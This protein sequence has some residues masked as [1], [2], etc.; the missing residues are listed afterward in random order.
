MSNFLNKIPV[1][2]ITSFGNPSVPNGSTFGTNFSILQTGG[3]MEVFTLSGLTYTIPPATTGIIEF[4]G[5]SIPIQFTKGSGSVFSPDVLTL[6]SDN[7]SSGRRKLGMLAY[8]YE[9]NKIYQF[10]I[11][12]YDTLWNSATGATG[13][14]GPTVV[15]SDFG[16]TVKNNSVAGQSF[17]NAWT[18]ST[19]S[20]VGGYDDTNASWRVLSTG[21]SGGGGASITGGTFDKNTETLSLNNSTGGTITITGFTDVFVTGGTYSDGTTT[22]TNN[23]GGTFTVSGYFTGQTDNY[24]TGGTFNKNTETLSLFDLTGGT[25][26]ITG[27]TDVFVTG[28]TYSGG[29]II[30]TNNSGGTFNVE[31]LFTGATDVFVTGGTYSSGTTTFTNNTGGTFQ[32]TG[33]T[34]QGDYVESVT[35]DGV[36]NTDPLNPVISQN[37][38]VNVITV[39]LGDLGLLQFE[40]NSTMLLLANS[41]LNSLNDNIPYDT[42]YQLEIVEGTGVTP[43]FLTT[44]VSRWSV[45]NPGD[46]I[47]LP[48]EVG[49]SYSGGIDWGD[50]TIT[51]N[52]YSNRTHTYTN[53]GN[54]TIK[55]NGIISK[56]NFFTGSNVNRANIREIIQWGNLDIGNN[57][58][59][60]LLCSNLVLTGVTD[61]LKL[62]SGT[63]N[64]SNMFQLCTS[65]TSINNMNDW[66]TSN[67]TNMSG[68]FNNATQFNQP[69]G[70]WDVSNV[71]IMSSMF[72]NCI[73][74][75]QNIGSWDVSNVTTMG[76]MFFITS[77]TGNF[78]NGGSPSI[79]NWNTVSVT[80]MSYMFYSQT[81]FNQ[82]ID[83]WNVSN[84]QNMTFMFR[85]TTFNQ[86][87]S[88][89]NVSNVTNM[90][91]MF[92]SSS[93]NQPIGNW[94]V[95]KVT[96]MAQ[97]FDFGA[98]FNQ[99]IGNWNISGV[100]GFVFFMANKTPSTFSTTNLDAIYNGWSTKNPKPNR[101]I[102]FGTAKYTAAGSAGRAVL[103]GTYGWTIT[104]G[105]I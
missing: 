22:F 56:F 85:N 101:N 16:T 44:F 72:L 64:L 77:L 61:T 23:T 79:N 29:T 49:G 24:I 74:F 9:T 7:I 94:N 8:V 66:N 60:F 65:I 71:T 34:K 21:G 84:V 20:G 5:N 80:D 69:I 39:T 63:T 15:I 37:A 102:S 11:D 13:P 2:P 99:D 45:T 47:T 70:S 32:V 25:I 35:G 97:M 30:F 90:S 105:G 36:D 41:Y 27:F 100:T 46:S 93:F 52:S 33:Y 10:R 1:S 96:N 50:G 88:G 86:P 82:P 17:I 73:N 67:V 12:N 53:S 95:S 92:R 89:W 59:Y 104:D 83:G 4:S 48:Y 76:S 91:V 43:T 81:L 58:S 19:I 55:I 87:L 57:G 18:A 103:T 75:N 42:L 54:Y 62:L 98:Q 6:N 26:T 78:N 28:G 51:S 68:M 31:G 40:D 38:K 3:F 14:G